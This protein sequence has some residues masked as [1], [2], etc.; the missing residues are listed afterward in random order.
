MRQ[1][2]CFAF[3]VTKDILG[4]CSPVEVRQLLCVCMCVHTRVCVGVVEGTWKADFRF[5][6]QLSYIGDLGICAVFILLL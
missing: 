1:G 3:D 2:G 4:P 6:S 5:R